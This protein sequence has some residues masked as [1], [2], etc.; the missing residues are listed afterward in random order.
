MV[1]QPLTRGSAPGLV[2]CT[3]SF[4]IE[5]PILVQSYQ[6]TSRL[7]VFADLEDGGGPF[8]VFFIEGPPLL[9]LW[10][11]R[12]AKCLVTCKARWLRIFLSWFVQALSGYIRRIMIRIF[13]RCKYIFPSTCFLLA[14]TLSNLTQNMLIFSLKSSLVSCLVHFNFS[15]NLI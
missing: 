11:Q 6:Q 7:I 2:T 4:G 13:Q 14:S 1:A 5:L 9:T 10:S 3:V 15:Q 12:Y 8:C